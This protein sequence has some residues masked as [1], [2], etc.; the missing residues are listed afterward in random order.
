MLDD[1]LLEV[2]RQTPVI[3]LQIEQRLSPQER[4][5]LVCAARCHQAD[6]FTF[7]ELHFG[8]RIVQS[9]HLSAIVGRLV[10]KGFLVKLG[11][12]KYD[13]ATEEL[14]LHLRYRHCGQK[15]LR[16]HDQSADRS[17]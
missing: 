17:V 12:G 10:K 9:S 16:L 14:R 7:K 6:P 1:I 4:K 15:I 5:V 13:F 3:R 8:S 2:D 11:R